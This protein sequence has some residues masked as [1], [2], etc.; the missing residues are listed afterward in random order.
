MATFI[1]LLVEVF[2][3]LQRSLYNTKVE[4]ASAPDLEAGGNPPQR[5]DLVT[6]RWRGNSSK[7]IRVRTEK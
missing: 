5:N 2:K 3:V 1:I 4:V 7:S 6:C